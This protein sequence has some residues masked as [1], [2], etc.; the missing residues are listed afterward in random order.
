MGLGSQQ[1]AGPQWREQ[2]RSFIQQTLSPWCVLDAGGASAGHT[3]AGAKAV[4]VTIAVCHWRSR[5]GAPI[6]HGPSGNTRWR[7]KRPL[8]GGS[9]SVRREQQMYIESFLPGFRPPVTGAGPL[10]LSKRL[11][12]DGPCAPMTPPDAH[13]HHRPAHP[14]HL[15]R[16]CR[17]CTHS[18]H[19]VFTDKHV[20]P[21]SPFYPQ[22]Q[23]SH[24]RHF[25]VLPCHFFSSFPPL[26]SP[27]ESSRGSPRRGPQP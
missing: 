21:V 18:F 1:A 6:S 19:P 12:S 16:C 22:R 23:P 7:W 11:F 10:E 25:R 26:S 8:G 20:L 17:L 4:L 13:S 14:L 5:E 9:L 3:Q 27:Q 2:G 15:H 24:P